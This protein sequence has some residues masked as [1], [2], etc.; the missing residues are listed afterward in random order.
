MGNVVETTS[1]LFSLRKT[2]VFQNNNPPYTT[3][4]TYKRL[5]AF[6]RTLTHVFGY[7]KVRS[8]ISWG[9]WP[10]PLNRVESRTVNV[11]RLCDHN[12]NGHNKTDQMIDLKCFCDTT[13]KM[14][15]K[16]SVWMWTQNY[17][18]LIYIFWVIQNQVVNLG[19][20]ELYTVLI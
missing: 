9:F 5:G 1:P 4:L 6:K 7:S 8:D 14:V 20:V 10:S 3:T 13:I 15:A 18:C 12:F 19:S 17:D 11:S 16:N 2:L